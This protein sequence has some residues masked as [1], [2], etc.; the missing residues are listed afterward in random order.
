M[1]T[2]EFQLRSGHQLLQGSEHGQNN[3]RLARV[4]L[5]PEASYS[6]SVWHHKADTNRHII[7]L[8]CE[9]NRAANHHHCDLEC[10]VCCLSKPRAAF[11]ENYLKHKLGSTTRLRCIDCWH[12]PCMF[13][14]KCPTCIHCRDEKCKVRANCSKD[15]KPL[16][17]GELPMTMADVKN[18]A[19]TRCR[20]VRCTVRQADGTLCGKERR[21]NAQATARKK[22]Q[23]YTCG[24]CETWLLSQ[25]SLRRSKIVV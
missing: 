7:C 23:E 5:V 24:D 13:M 12:P 1:S 9:K 25:E 6:Q 19:C 16:Q 22:K 18:F 3:C 8:A 21:H 15:I 11:P 2:L 20:Y 4:T 10:D 14:T 17:R